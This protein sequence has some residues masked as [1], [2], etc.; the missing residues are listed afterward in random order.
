MNTYFLYSIAGVFSSLLFTLQIRSMDHDKRV[1]AS[2]ISF[3]VTVLN[4]GILYAIFTNLQGIAGIM[5]YAVG[6]G[7]GTFIAM[8]LKV[9][10][11][12]KDLVG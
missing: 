10:Y 7:I 11:N 8:R 12:G 1:A 2:L 6:V 3:V 5:S 4:L 9:R